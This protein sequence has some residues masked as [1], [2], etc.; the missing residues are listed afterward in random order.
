MSLLSNDYQKL[1]QENIDESVKLNGKNYGMLDRMMRY[2]SAHDIAL[3]ALEVVKKDLIG[4]AKEAE[5]EQIPLEEKIGVPEKEFCDTLLDGAMKKRHIDSIMLLIRDMSL[6]ICLFN[7]VEFFCFGCPEI[8]GLTLGVL[9]YSAVFVAFDQVVVEK[10]KGRTLY[11]K[12]DKTRNVILFTVLAI[13]F[14]IWILL[15]DELFLIRGNGW[16]ITILV[17]VITGLIYIGN[18]YYWNRQSKKYNWQ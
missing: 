2:I 16:L 3:F 7:T 17:I 4:I 5:I 9:F 11:N 12:N 6:V 15:P 18:N 14:L 1:R 13:G 8:F 10:L